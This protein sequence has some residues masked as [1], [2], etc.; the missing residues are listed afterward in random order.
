LIEKQG[1]GPE[2]LSVLHDETLRRP[3]LLK[4]ERNMNA[5]KKLGVRHK[6]LVAPILMCAAFLFMACAPDSGFNTVDD[7]DVVVTIYDKDF[8]YNSLASYTLVDTVMHI[9]DEDNPEEEIS[10]E[11]DDLILTTVDNN[12]KAY[13]YREI[14]DPQQ[15]TPDVF[16]VIQVTNSKHTGA[17]Y[18]PGYGGWCG[19]W[20]YY[21]GWPGW[22]PGWG[23]Y[24]PPGYWYSYEF[25]TGTIFI[26]FWDGKNSSDE[27]IIIRWQGSMNGLLSSSG[28][29]PEARISRG[30]SKAFEQSPYLKQTN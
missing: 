20:C 18:V 19:Y 24:Y 16:V 17:G 21:P 25:S 23:G 9:I 30:I 13:G 5:S 11:Y 26:D 2:Y 1:G 27:D 22:G 8:N 15:E 3:F 28:S 7:Y 29:G 12:M 14:T 10:R 4:E 6:L